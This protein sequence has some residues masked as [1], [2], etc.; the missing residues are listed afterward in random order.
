MVYQLSCLEEEAMLKLKYEFEIDDIFLDEQILTASL[1]L[2]PW[3]AYF[4]NY[5]VCD[6][7]PEDLS[8]YQHKKFMS[9]VLLGRSILVLKLY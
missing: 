3:F 8:F 1:D 9:I 2:I 4:V 5:L 7:I 6:A